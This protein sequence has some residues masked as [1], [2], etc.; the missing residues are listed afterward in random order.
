MFDPKLFWRAAAVSFETLDHM[1]AVRK[2]GFLT[3]IGEVKIR[4]Q[5][6]VLHLKDF[7]FLYVCLTALSL[8]LIHI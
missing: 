4:E 8:S 5:E 3:D 2:A 7:H 1:A 6:K